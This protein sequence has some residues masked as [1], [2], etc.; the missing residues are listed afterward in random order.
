MQLRSEAALVVD[1]SET[2]LIASVYDGHNACMPPRMSISTT[3]AVNGQEAECV[4]NG[5]IVLRSGTVKTSKLEKC[6]IQ[7]VKVKVEKYGN[8]SGKVVKM[9]VAD[10]PQKPC[11]QTTRNSSEL[12]KSRRHLAANVENKWFSNL[13]ENVNR[14]TSKTRITFLAFHQSRGSV[15]YHCP[16]HY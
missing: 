7:T 15:T 8:I 1:P 16:S 4:G 6:G 13:H 2:E 10:V 9:K 11:K 12:A 3:R 14:P 5:S